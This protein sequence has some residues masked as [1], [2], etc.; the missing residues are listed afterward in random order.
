MTEEEKEIDV[1][2]IGAGPAGII[3]SAKAAESGANVLLLEKN[4]NLGRKILLTGKGRCNL[5]NAEFDLRKL[6]KNYGKN[7]K[8]LFHAFSVFGPKEVIN[9][10]KKINL[11]TKI[12]RGN[13]VFPKSDKAT[14]V[15]GVLNKHLKKNK[16]KVIYNSKV[17]RIVS[18]NNKI[19]K[20]IIKNNGKEEEMKARKY[21]FCTGGKSYPVTG[22]TG[23][24]FNWAKKLGHN[25]V[26]PKPALAPIEIKEKWIKNLQGLS[27][28]NVEI[29]AKTKNKTYFKE[30][31]EC[32][33]THFGLSG[34]IVLNISKKIGELLKDNKEIKISIDLKP[35]LS[36]Q[37]LDK[38][39][40]RDLKKHQNKSFRNSLDDL[41]PSKI[42]PIIL[43][44]S[45]ISLEKKANSVTREERHNLVRLIK[46]LKL[47][48]IKVMG[49]DF[50]IVTSGGVSL[51]EINDKTMKSKIID[52]LF[53]A[54]EIIDIDGPTGGF[55][56]QF[57]WS[58]GY[59]AGI[60]MGIEKTIT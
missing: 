47:T 48:A 44:L 23:D 32:L 39:A 53:F 22:S 51:K 16:V 9:F 15:L 3:A 58:T 45:D 46:N 36:F 27:L 6:V 30:F 31:G 14:S 50:A 35:A 42:I 34:P 52:N 37:E 20:I 25:V 2:V 29:S 41:F 11:K 43:K 10:F 55:N 57:C 1:I 60:A 12:E 40:Q 4:E 8:F 7:G 5:T 38:R 18:K 33:F 13:R 54:G 19:Q 56:L 26:E 59:L 17:T 49:F 28:K 24:G 21:I